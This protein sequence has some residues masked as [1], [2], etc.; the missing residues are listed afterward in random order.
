MCDMKHHKRPTKRE[1][2]E[3]IQRGIED[4]EFWEIEDREFWEKVAKKD[5]K[6]KSK[7]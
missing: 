1:V 3:T 6:L 5:E 7:K 4:R 2:R